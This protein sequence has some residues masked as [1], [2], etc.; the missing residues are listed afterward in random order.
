MGIFHPSATIA[1]I[2]GNVGGV[3]YSRNR[4]GPITRGLINQVNPDTSY[5]NAVRAAFTQAVADYQAMTDETFEEYTAFVND[6]KQ[7]GRLSREFRRS[8]FNEYMSRQM[9]R[10]LLG[11]A[12]VYP[13][14]YPTVRKHPWIDSVT[15]G[16]DTLE[17]AT[18]SLEATGFVSVAVY[19]SALKSPG[20]R[21]VNPDWCSFITF[22]DVATTDHTFD[23]Y[24][25]YIARFPYMGDPNGKRIFVAIKAINNDNYRQGPLVFSSAI[26]SGWPETFDTFDDTF[27]ET[28]F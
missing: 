16:T 2:R 10:F 17:V 3:N 27:D 11:G 20:I 6:V 14:A 12:T 22:A 23:I 19:A 13:P 8:V 9:N 21:A 25:E 24:D 4:Y 7:H 18:D 28:F 1:E 15:I 5:Q 26:V